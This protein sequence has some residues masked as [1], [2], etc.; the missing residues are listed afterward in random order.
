MKDPSDA[1]L[2]AF[3]TALNGN[4]AYGSTDFPVYTFAP[5]ADVYNYVLLEDVSLVDDSTKDR[6]ESEGTIL[7]E[8][9]HGGMSKRGTL[10]GV[11]DVGNDILLLTV[12]TA[13]TVSGFTWAVTPYVDNINILKEPTETSIIARKLIRLRFIIRQT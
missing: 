13:I 4:L 10:K 11:N 1:I 12:K 3:Y 8:V 9:V 6:Y 5:K 2:T 7:I